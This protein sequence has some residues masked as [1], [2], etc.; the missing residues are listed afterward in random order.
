MRPTDCECINR[1]FLCHRA[2]TYYAV[3]VLCGGIT[4]GYV[5]THYLQARNDVRNIPATRRALHRGL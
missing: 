1:D 4:C 3:V 2:V 5:D